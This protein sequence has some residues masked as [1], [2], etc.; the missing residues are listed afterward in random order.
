VHHINGNPYDNSIDNLIGLCTT[1]HRIAE[2]K[3]PSLD[4]L[5]NMRKRLYVLSTAID[6][7]IGWGDEEIK[8]IADG[9]HGADGFE[10]FLIQYMYGVQQRY[11]SGLDVE[12][13]IGE[14][15][16]TLRHNSGGGNS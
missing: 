12:K 8:K 5:E 11:E 2:G 14:D 7:I 3:K 6:E 13:V 10:D 4:D 1:C 9:Q 15:R 16:P